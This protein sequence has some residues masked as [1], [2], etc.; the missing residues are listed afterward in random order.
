MP[1]KGDN[2]RVE[3]GRL[4]DAYGAGLYRYALMILGNATS[5]EDALRNC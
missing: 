5:A 2:P 1:R 3:V 4:Y